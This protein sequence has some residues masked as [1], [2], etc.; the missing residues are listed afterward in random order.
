MPLL[1]WRDRDADL[2]RAALVPYRLLEPV[3]KLSHGEPDSHN[4]LIEGD[5]L[6]A[7]KALIPYYSGQ[8]KC[9][10]ID[11]P[12]NT[13]AAFDNYDDNVEHSTWLS[14]MY[15]RLVLLRDLMHPAGSIFV[16][17][18]DNELD[19]CR[20]VMDEIFGRGNFMNRVTVEARSPSAFS[21]VNP[22]V[23]KEAEYILWYAKDRRQFK[24]VPIRVVRDV[25]YAYKLWL[26]N[27]DEPFG[28]WTF[29]SIQDEYQKVP[30]NK[31][32]VHPKSIL[33]H[34]DKFVLDN[35]KR[36]CR[37]ASISET[38]AGEA[39]VTLKKKSDA[40]PG[41]I[42]MLDRGATL[43]PVYVMD[44]QQILFYGKNVVTIDGETKASSPLTNVWSDISWEGIAAE[45]GVK[46]KK[47]K[48]PERLI[49][50]CLE[51]ATE[52]G[53]LVLDSFLGSGTTAAVAHKMGRRWIGVEIGEH[54]VTHGAVR[55]KAVVDGEQ[56][57]ISKTVGWQ[58]GGGFRFLKL[59]PPIFDETGNVRAGIK[60][61]HL[62]AHVWFS[63]TGVPRSSR[64]KKDVFLGEHEG[65][66]YYLLF[67][68]I[69]GDQT[70][71]GGNVLSRTLLRRLPKF[72]G[73][74]VIYGEACLLPE[75]QL[76][77]LQITFKQ[78]PYDLKAR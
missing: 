60:F 3:D 12:F 51:L 66:A 1:T 46:F 18:D 56:S 2:T 24:D 41:Q 71:T 25:D 14:L 49:K 32:M 16:H 76:S 64:A 69:L 40:K 75:E 33:S 63:E 52:P 30:R 34:F 73:P 5:N 68:G 37:L 27:P 4:L 21:T 70:A 62:A 42:F 23:F 65:I 20:V 74:K 78:T 57:G 45:G 38:G 35:A 7:L 17:L 36:V 43:D 50:R 22:G 13:G 72:D 19:Y 26:D 10:Y 15:A 53:D 29:S 59:G 6:A 47:G 8:V 77:D 48:K 54:A 55:L 67:N 9:V 39:I 61:E 31:R 44:G 11:P 28:K 58:G